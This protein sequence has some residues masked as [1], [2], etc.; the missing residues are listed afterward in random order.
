M[1][2]TLRK[3]SKASTFFK[4]NSSNQEF[5]AICSEGLLPLLKAEILQNGLTIESENRG[6][7]FFTGSV[8][9]VFSFLAATEVSS[10]VGLTLAGF[11]ILDPEEFYN[12][13]IDL[14]WESFLGP[15]TS[16][17]IEGKTKDCLPDSRFA[18]YK[19]K[20]A[21]LDRFRKLEKPFPD[22]DLESPDLTLLIR[23]F[24]NQ[25][26]IEVLLHKHSLTK[27]GYRQKAGDATLR[28]NIAAGLLQF[29]GW[30]ESSIL[31]DPYCG[32]GTI[33][34]EAALRLKSGTMKNKNSFLSKR[35][36]YDLFPEFDYENFFKNNQGKAF[37]QPHLIGLDISSNAIDQARMDAKK[38]GVEDWI[39]F[40]QGRI[41]EL[42]FI[43]NAYSE[44]IPLF[45]VTDPPFGKRLGTRDD[46]VE[47]YRELGEFVKENLCPSTLCIITSDPSLLGYLKLRKDSE[48]SLKNANLKSKIVKYKIEWKQ[49]KS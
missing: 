25:V 24:L 39:Y 38:A 6:G 7:V 40:S 44:E 3:N 15:R 20:D 13:A 21:I 42:P 34:I 35:I 27:R 43:L 29:S 30:D 31:I 2:S 36:I 14:P 1:R 10:K 37:D 49:E 33:L 19:L 22:V 5:H 8:E 28:E 4:S 11:S 23:S 18:I 12:K 32:Q 17:K 47:I 48:I 46:A 26:R 45:I 9:K 16:F 41:Q